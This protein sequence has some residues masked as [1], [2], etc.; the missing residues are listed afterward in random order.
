M[1]AYELPQNIDAIFTGT[2][3]TLAQLSRPLTLE[4]M[5]EERTRI[6]NLKHLLEQTAKKN[7]R[8]KID[9]VLLTGN[10]FDWI[11]GRILET[12]NFDDMYGVNTIVLSENG[13]VA[14][15]RKEGTYWI[16]EPTDDYK[17][18]VS[19]IRKYAES[20]FSGEFWLQGNMVRTTFKPV[21]GREENFEAEFVP[22]IT[23][24]A[25][26]K[27]N[28]KFMHFEDMLAFEETE[29]ILYHNKGSSIDIEPVWVKTGD[30]KKEP[31]Y[32]KRGVERFNGK[33]T[34]VEKISERRAYRNGN[35]VCV[36]R[37]A[38]D[39]LMFLA[40][41]DFGGYSF[42]S[43]KDNDFKVVERYFN[44][45]ELNVKFLD[46]PSREILPNLLK[47]YASNEVVK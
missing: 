34:G 38:S 12:Y 27:N 47:S 7:D 40:V 1:S 17:A 22:A 19:D 35:V 23:R 39:L 25:K 30:G 18:F 43:T 13:L 46:L 8:E 33:A 42:A 5:V 9:L 6:E 11:R 44:L 4:E 14:Q 45:H 29:G 16:R 26:K 37:S 15:S 41:N 36:G 20:K 31:F 3:D 10:S 24:Y 21:K 2:H 32:G 28:W